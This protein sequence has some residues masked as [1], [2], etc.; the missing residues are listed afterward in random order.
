FQRI[1]GTILGLLK[2]I[3]RPPPPALGH[4]RHRQQPL[5]FTAIAGV[6]A[7]DIPDGEIVVGSLDD[8]NRISSS[9]VALGDDSQVSPRSQ[10]LREVA[11][12]HPVVHSNAKPPARYARLGNLKN[13][14]PDLPAFADKRVVHLNPFGREV[15]AKLTVGQRSANLLCP[16][17]CVFDGV[18][19]ERL[20][21]PAVRLAI[22][23]VIAGEIDTSGRD[24]AGDRGF[25]DRA[26]GGP[27]VVFE[28]THVADVDAQDLADGSCHW[29]PFFSMRRAILWSAAR[30]AAFIYFALYSR[31]G[32]DAV[33]QT[34]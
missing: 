3:G 4:L 1:P 6:D 32:R 23:L 25:P 15:F 27:A 33:A 19:V 17:A 20:V 12:K 30:I 9:H 16:P 5:D 8:P 14:R 2:P 11:R 28:M 18:G 22:R 7:K 24:P 21:G 34:N 29:L 10:R 26:L 31:Y 13:G